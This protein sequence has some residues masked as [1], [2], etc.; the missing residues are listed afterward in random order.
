MNKPKMV[1]GRKHL[2]MKTFYFIGFY[3]FK[4]QFVRKIILIV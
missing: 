4:T 2:M 1:D 3:F